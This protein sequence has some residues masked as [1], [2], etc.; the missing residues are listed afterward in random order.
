M[1]KLHLKYACDALLS[2]EAL[3]FC[4]IRV[5]T[6]Y[7]TGTLELKDI[8]KLISYMNIMYLLRILRMHYEQCAFSCW[9]V[10]HASK[11]HIYIHT[12]TTSYTLRDTSHIYIMHAWTKHNNTKKYLKVLWKKRNKECVHSC[13]LNQC[14]I[15]I[16]IYFFKSTSV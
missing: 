7:S 9:Y 10:K 11:L 13:R 1:A 3:S 12:Y 14:Y 16:Y 8:W 5:F 2:M 15:Y 4:Q 6:V